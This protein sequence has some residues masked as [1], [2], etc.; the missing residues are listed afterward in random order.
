MPRLAILGANPCTGPLFAISSRTA[1]INARMG[2]E[3]DWDLASVHTRAYSAATAATC[4]GELR[5]SMAGRT[6][7]AMTR[8]MCSRWRA[9]ARDKI[10]VDSLRTV[11]ETASARFKSPRSGGTMQHSAHT[12]SMTNCVNPGTMS[13]CGPRTR[14][15]VSVRGASGELSAV[16]ASTKDFKDCR[17]T[18]RTLTM[19]C[20]VAA[21]IKRLIIDSRSSVDACRLSPAKTSVSKPFDPSADVVVSHVRSR[22]LASR[23]DSVLS[24]IS[25]FAV[26]DAWAYSRATVLNTCE[27]KLG[28]IST[29]NGASIVLYVAK[30]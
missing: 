11:T 2:F 30:S 19:E 28:R 3:L 9:N 26:A 25:P 17:A 10:A 16:Q 12:R 13:C 4:S 5:G 24:A 22:S 1:S 20:D 18:F 14:A 29:T 15:V 7:R 8:S 23:T 6:T 27:V 21:S